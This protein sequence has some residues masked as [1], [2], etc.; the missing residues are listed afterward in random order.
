MEDKLLQRQK[1]IWQRPTVCTVGVPD[2]QE[3]FQ[4]RP[5]LV[6]GD[7]PS[8]PSSSES[9]KRRRALRS[10]SGDTLTVDLGENSVN[11]PEL[12]PDIP[13]S[14]DSHGAKKNKKKRRR[15]R[16]S[17]PSDS[18]SG[19]SSSSRSHDRKKSRKDGTDSGGFDEPSNVAMLPRS[20]A[21]NPKPKGNT[22]RSAYIPKF[23][24]DFELMAPLLDP[25]MARK[26]LRNLGESSDRAKLKDFWEKQLLSLQR[27]VKDAFQPLAYM[28]GVMPKNSDAEMPVQ[29]AIRLLGHVF[30][31]I[32]K[33]RRSN[34]MRHCA[35]KFSTMLIDNR[36]FSSRDYRNLFGNK[37]IDALEKEAI[38]D[39]KMDQIGRYGGPSNSRGGNTHFRK[40]GSNSGSG[41]NFKSNGNWNFNKPHSSNRNKSGGQ[42]FTGAS[43]KYVSNFLP[44]VSSVDSSIVGGRL[45]LFSNAWQVFT[46]DPWIL[47]I[48]E[49]GYSIEFTHPHVQKL[50]PPEVIMDKEK[51]SICN[52]EVESLKKKGAIVV[53]PSPVDRIHKATLETHI[54]N[55]EHIQRYHTP[56]EH[57]QE[58]GK[59]KPPLF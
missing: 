22:L 35:P 25:S 52:S 19:S 15:S 38:A 4:L 50:I 55:T 37:F 53:A 12:P 49:Y 39:A 45:S 9:T 40:G 31:R 46:D 30:S 1:I 51:T 13:N 42:Q 32:T 26:W 2:P 48:I 17:S 56:R 47:N 33:M 8:S 10:M 3:P 28:L 18:G 34:S 57:R 29:T 44:P 5:N 21:L 11:T 43:N 59:R 58:E 54:R 7:I 36:L 41:A 6:L 23:E 20:R 27:E 16:D 14:T 24:G